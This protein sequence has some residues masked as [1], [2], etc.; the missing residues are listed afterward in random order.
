MPQTFQFVFKLNEATDE[1][2]GV[3][4]CSPLAFDLDDAT[5]PIRKMMVERIDKIANFEF[6]HRLSFP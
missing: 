2:D 6:R 5:N 3:S 4:D 1:I